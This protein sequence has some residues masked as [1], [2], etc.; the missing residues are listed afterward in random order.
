[1]GK[2]CAISWTFSSVLWPK[3]DRS[4]TRSIHVF[5]CFF[6]CLS[7]VL[8]EAPRRDPAPADVRAEHVQQRRPLPD[9]PRAA[10]RLEAADPVPEREGRGGLRVPRLVVAPHHQEGQARRSRYVEGAASDDQGVDGLMG[11]GGEDQF[12]SVY[13]TRQPPP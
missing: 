8:A 12:F 10:Q 1:M 5:F 4:S 3:P 13:P 11:V 9:L 2:V 6:F 7:G